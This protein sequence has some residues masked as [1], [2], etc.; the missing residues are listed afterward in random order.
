LSVIDPASRLD[1]ITDVGILDGRIAAIR[2]GPAIADAADAIDARGL[3]VT[4]RDSSTFT[5]T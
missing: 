5:R 1:R 4:G 2:T 3:I